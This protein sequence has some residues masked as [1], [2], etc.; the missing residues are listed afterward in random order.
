[1]SLVAR[2]CQLLPPIPAPA[3]RYVNDS[4]GKAQQANRKRPFHIVVLDIGDWWTAV[5]SHLTKQKQ[6]VFSGGGE[7][8]PAII[9]LKSLGYWH[10]EMLTIQAPPGHPGQPAVLLACGLLNQQVTIDAPDPDLA[11]GP[12][13]HRIKCACNDMEIV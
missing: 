10:T 7:P 5:V 6:K 3:I 2:E 12:M 8:D 4:A 13:Q 11:V 1:M 9:D